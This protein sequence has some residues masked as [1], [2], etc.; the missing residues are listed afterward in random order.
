MLIFEIIIL[1]AKD[2]EILTHKIILLTAEIQIFRK[3]NK[4]LANTTRPK[5]LVSVKEIY[6]L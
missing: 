4:T 2:T 6:L 3:V 1:L 5:K